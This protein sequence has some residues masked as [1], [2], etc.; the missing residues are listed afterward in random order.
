MILIVFDYIDND[1]LR[2]GHHYQVWGCLTSGTPTNQ[3]S[4]AS[5]SSVT[6][7]STVHLVVV[8]CLVLQSLTE[9]Q[10]DGVLGLVL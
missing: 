5:H 4:A 7:H 9:L 2:L 8:L 10:R 3:L 6:R 1:C